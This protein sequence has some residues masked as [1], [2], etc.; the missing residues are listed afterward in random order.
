LTANNDVAVDGALA[1]TF[2]MVFASFTGAGNG[3]R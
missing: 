2:G 1:P 3:S